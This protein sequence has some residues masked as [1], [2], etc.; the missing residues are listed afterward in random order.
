MSHP[1]IM[2][3][4]AGTSDIAVADIFYFLFFETIL[5]L[6]VSEREML[7]KQKNG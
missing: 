2:K 4:S 6:S 3:S 1:F 5:L 7:N